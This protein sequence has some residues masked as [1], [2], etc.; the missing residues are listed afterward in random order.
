[1]RQRLA[2][3]LLLFFLVATPALGL[4]ATF[5]WLRGAAQVWLTNSTNVASGSSILSATI[6]LT[7][8]NYTRADCELNVPAWSTTV[9]ANTAVVVWLIRSVDAT[10]NYEDGA[11]ATDPARTPDIV[12]PLRGAISTAQRVIIPNIEL[13]RGLFKALVKNDGTG[14]A[15]NGATTAWT[16]TCTPF[17]LQSL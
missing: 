2:V 7:S 14:A 8:A 13:P 12:F 16:L 3:G 11:A 4:A 10:P 6:T 1:M 5:V 9:T 17:I 15:M